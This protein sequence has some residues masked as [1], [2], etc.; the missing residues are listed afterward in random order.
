MGGTEDRLR[1]LETRVGELSS[2]LRV[3]R[4]LVEQDHASAL[5]KIRYVTEKVLHELCKRESVTWGNSEPTVENMIGPLIAKKVIPKNVALHVRTIQTNASPGSHFQESPLTATHVQLAQIALI[6][7]LEWYYKVDSSPGAPASA[8]VA[9]APPVARPIPRAW[10]V[11]VGIGAVVLIAALGFSFYWISRTGTPPDAPVAKAPPPPPPPALHK[12]DVGLKAI[13]SFR[14]PRGSEISTLDSVPFWENAARDL[15]D[16]AKQA[17]APKD[18]AAGAAFC[19]GQAFARGGKDA[20]AIDAFHVAI[21]LSPSMAVAHAALGVVLAREGKLDDAV[22]EAAQAERYDP[23]WW[24]AVAA[25]ARVYTIAGK[26]DLAIQA[27]R[28]AL[29][30][31]KDQPVLLAE[32]A[33]VYHFQHLDSEAERLAHQAIKLDPDMMPAHLLLAERALEVGKADDAITEATSAVA[34]GPDILSAWLALGDAQA[35]AHH[36]A[37]ALDAYKRAL[38]LWHA[39]GMKVPS[40]ERMKLVETAVAAGKMPPTRQQQAAAAQPKK[41]PSEVTIPRA[42]PC[43]QGDPLCGLQ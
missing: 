25:Q 23:A 14:A 41:K 13:D 9:P 16:A 18:W 8:A 11:I 36:D 24:G 10:F 39:V 31:A 1:T 22:A 37:Q 15:D 3:L 34:V 19:R 26:Y 12:P 28:R 21:E 42:A 43:A 35:L 30:A 7:V 33:L 20:P 27:Y 40:E 5:N 4:T 17:G 2:D 29:T 32:L 38:E 6:D